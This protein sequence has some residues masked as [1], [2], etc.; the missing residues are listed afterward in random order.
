MNLAKLWSEAEV[1][2]PLGFVDENMHTVG[3]VVLKPNLPI[4]LSLHPGE[5]FELNTDII[6]EWKVVFQT[7][8]GRVIGDAN[9]SSVL[10]EL[11]SF[12]IDQQNG[13]I[14]VRALT[15]EDLENLHASSLFG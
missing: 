13:S 1:A 8:D 7:S 15:D 3:A 12:V 5:D 4:I 9:Y 2:E 14:L 11:H 10:R 6:H